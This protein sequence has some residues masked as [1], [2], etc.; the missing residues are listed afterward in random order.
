MIDIGDG[1]KGGEI[2]KIGD[3]KKTQKGITAAIKLIKSNTPSQDET[4][5]PI[6]SHKLESSE[7]GNKWVGGK[8]C[9]TK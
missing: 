1:K 2:P 3:G 8:G 9:I 7:G 4:K 5:M 6:R